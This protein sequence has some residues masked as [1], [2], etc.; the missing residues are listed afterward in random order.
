MYKRQRV[1]SSAAAWA[2]WHQIRDAGEAKGKPA[3]TSTPAFEMNAPVPTEAEPAARAV[4]AGA[5]QIV[6]EV[7]PAPSSSDSIASIVDRVLADLRPRLVEEIARKMA[8]K[9]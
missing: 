6:Q 1:A 8:E 2:S 9:K 5:E 3:E 7:S 4:A